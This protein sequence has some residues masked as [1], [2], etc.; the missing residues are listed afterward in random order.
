MLQLIF[1]HIR[2]FPA[3]LGYHIFVHPGSIIDYGIDNLK[4]P[5][6]TL[7][8]HCKRETSFSFS[9]LEIIIVITWILHESE[10]S[11]GKALQGEAIVNYASPL[12]T[13]HMGASGSP[14]G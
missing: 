8:N 13:Q 11:I 5:I 4:I 6:I 12:I 3:I 10:V 2:F 9:F 14:A 7:T 1:G